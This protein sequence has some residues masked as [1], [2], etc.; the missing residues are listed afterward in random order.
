MRM[1]FKCKI[2]VYKIASCFLFKKV[3]RKRLDDYLKISKYRELKNVFDEINNKKIV[4]ENNLD[5]IDSIFLGTSHVAY[6]VN[7]K[8]FGN[9]SYNLGSTSQDLFTSYSL[10]K[11]VTKYKNINKIFIEYAIFSNGFDL[12]YIKSGVD[13]T[14]CYGYLYGIDYKEQKKIETNKYLLKDIENNFRIN[15]MNDNGYLYPPPVLSASDVQE[16]AKKHMREHKRT[17][18]Q[19]FYFNKISEIAK[20]NN[21]KLYVVTFPVRSDLIKFFPDKDY[22][23]KDINKMAEEIGFTYLNFYN[24]LEFEWND[25]WD[26]DH[27]NENG[28]EKFTK[29]LKAVIKN[30]EQ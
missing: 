30:M 1:I 9:K 27:L 6:G 5:N 23:F 15:I 12:A 11:K 18:S 19:M 3:W 16:R 14:S 8:F 26:Y 20:K 17:N 24:D 13:I 28:A 21:I 25:F 22:L 4:F 2:L 10:L 29:K 7:P